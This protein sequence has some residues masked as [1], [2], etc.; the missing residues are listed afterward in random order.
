MGGHAFLCSD[1]STATFASLVS[2]LQTTSSTDTALSGEQVPRPSRDPAPGPPTHRRCCHPL[3]INAPLLSWARAASSLSAV[4][5]HFQALAFHQPL[6]PTLISSH[7][8]SQQ[9]RAAHTRQASPGPTEP[10]AAPRKWHLQLAPKA[11][12]RHPQ[13][14]GPLSEDRFG[15]YLLEGLPPPTSSIPHP[16]ILLGVQ[17]I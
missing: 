4:T 14:W 11:F 3:P 6:P 2:H 17:C 1:I 12:L 16:S 5:L 10:G 15:S 9:L 7:R 13:A 8:S